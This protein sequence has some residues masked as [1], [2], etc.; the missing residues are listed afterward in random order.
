FGIDATAPDAPSA[1]FSAI[2]DAVTGIAEPGSTV[3]VYDDD[4][5]VLGTAPADPGTGEYTVVLDPALIDGEQVA[6][7]ATDA[8]GNESGPADATAPEAP[9]APAASLA[10]DTGTDGD[11][12][13]S[14]G[15]VE[16]DGLVTGATW[17]YSLD[18]GA[19]WIDG[20]DSSFVLPQGN[21]ADGQVQVRQL[22]GG[23]LPGPTASLPELSVIDLNAVDDNSL[24]DMGEQGV[25]VHTPETAEDVQVLGLAESDWGTDASTSFTVTEGYTGTTIIEVSQ[26]AL[27]AVADAFRLEVYDEDGNLVY[28]G[29]TEDSLVGDVGGLDILGLSGD[30]TLT[31]TLGGPAPGNYT[32]VVRNEESAL[33][34]LRDT[35]GG[36]VSL[37]ELGAAGVVLG[38]ENQ[39]VLLD[40]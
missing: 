12:V 35:D 32:V 37:Q 6:V 24:V 20:I 21:S 19:S 31:A 40:A 1:E 38:P 22:A 23:E 16:V 13:T 30:D 3:T 34:D 15:T 8:A 25:L 11:G 18:G 9:P 14:D 39:D 2:G 5:N 26:V 36:G 4:G 28:T 33:T 29:V 27:V 10:N 17:Q 7:T